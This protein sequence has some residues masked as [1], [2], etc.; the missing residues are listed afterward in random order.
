MRTQPG[1]TGDQPARRSSRVGLHSANF[2]RETAAEIAKKEK[3]SKK[4]RTVRR[5]AG[6][7]P[8]KK[9]LARLLH[10]PFYSFH[11]AEKP[12]GSFGGL[13]RRH[14]QGGGEV[15]WGVCSNFYFIQ[16]SVNDVPGSKC[17]RCVRVF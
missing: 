1:D 11:G 9:R 17:Q 14:K 2:S 4:E 7:V 13:F 12:P 5:A 3:R 6:D 16:Q 15:E 8:N 10:G